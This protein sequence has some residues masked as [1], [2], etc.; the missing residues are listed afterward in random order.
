ML[1]DGL[2]GSAKRETRRRAAEMMLAG[3]MLMIR[4]TRRRME[5]RA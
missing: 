3:A 5:A 2:A 1:H 4:I